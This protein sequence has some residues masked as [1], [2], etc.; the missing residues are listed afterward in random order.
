[1]L[2]IHNILYFPAIVYLASQEE[3][4]IRCMAC[5]S[6]FSS[7]HSSRQSG[8]QCVSKNCLPMY[9]AP[10]TMVDKSKDVFGFKNQASNT[11]SVEVSH[12]IYIEQLTKNEVSIWIL[13]TYL[14]LW[15]SLF[16]QA[17]CILYPATIQSLCLCQSKLEPADVHCWQFEE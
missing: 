7:L 15:S 2:S 3:W 14:H 6:D 13:D 16:M 11:D 5:C 8:C 4:T 10:E 17:C 1:M 9:A 12:Q